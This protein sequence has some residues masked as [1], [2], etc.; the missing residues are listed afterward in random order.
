M[1]VYNP[2]STL[3]AIYNLNPFDY[4]LKIPALV[5]IDTVESI[6]IKTKNLLIQ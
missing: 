5:N 4:I 1:S 2:S 6:D 3:E